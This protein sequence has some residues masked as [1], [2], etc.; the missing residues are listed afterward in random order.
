MSTVTLLYPAVAF[1][2]K[3]YLSSH[4]PMVQKTWSSK[5]LKSWQVSEL[6]PKSGYSTQC[7]LVWESEEAFGKAVQ[8]DEAKIM[9]D[10]PN[11]TEGKPTI[12]VGKVVGSS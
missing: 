11:Y 4:M 6:D 3:Y 9:G 2:L 1:D 12:L 10:I 7:V 5:G 8:E